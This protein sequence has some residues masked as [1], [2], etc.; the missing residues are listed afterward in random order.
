[1]LSQKV[2]WQNVLTSNLI[3]ELCGREEDESREYLESID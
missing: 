1:M 2:I 3:I